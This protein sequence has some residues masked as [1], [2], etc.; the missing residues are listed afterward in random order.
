[1]GR[2]LMARELWGSW[3]AENGVHRSLLEVVVCG[4]SVCNGVGSDSGED[5]DGGILVLL[6]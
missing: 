6:R 2:A 1:M 3:S 4:Q 5:D